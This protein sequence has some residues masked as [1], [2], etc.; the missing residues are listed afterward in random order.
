MVRQAPVTIDVTVARKRRRYHQDIAIH[1]HPLREDEIEVVRGLPVTCAARTA[2]DFAAVTR[3]RR[4]LERLWNEMEVRRLTSRVSVPMLLERYPGRPGASALRELL[5][6]ED[7]RGITRNDFEEAFLALLDAQGLPR[8]RLNADLSLRGRFIEVDCLW[9]RE[10]VAWELDGRTVHARKA[11]FESDR[12]RDR[13]LLAE[14]WR[15][16]RTTWLQLQEE[17]ADVA[18]DLRAVLTAPTLEGWTASSSSTTS[19]TRPA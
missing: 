6:S 10:R 18:T 5:G 9:P 12:K 1:R 11:A 4:E 3:E 14:G 17:P 15:P 2:F 13:E 7:P 19:R 8:P 16:G